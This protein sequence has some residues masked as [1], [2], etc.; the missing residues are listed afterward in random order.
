MGLLEFFRVVNDLQP[1]Y[2]DMVRAMGFGGLLDL[3]FKVSRNGVAYE[4]LRRFDVES[5]SLQVHGRKVQ[6][7]EGHVSWLLGLSCG[8]IE[9][10]SIVFNKKKV[11]AK[12]GIR[13]NKLSRKELVQELK[14]TDIGERWVALFLMLV[15]DC[16]LWPSSS[17]FVSHDILRVM[18]HSENLKSINWSK[19]V[20][21]GLVGGAK[22]LG[23]ISKE[24]V[25]GEKRYIPIHG[26]TILLE[27]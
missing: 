15:V 18:S 17:Y 3:N 14:R 25:A 22:K 12:Y 19:F 9:V 5:R 13:S 11:C 16:V 8:G 24:L 2:K 23:K 1:T 27:V 20:L 7:S 21:D 10:N 4:L 26:C 6:V